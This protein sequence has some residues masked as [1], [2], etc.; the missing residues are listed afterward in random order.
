MMTSSSPCLASPCLAGR[1]VSPLR[2]AAL[3]EAAGLALASAGGA[4]GVGD[5]P[6]VL[7]VDGVAALTDDDCW[8]APYR[9]WIEAGPAEDGVLA[10]AVRRAAH[11]DLFCSMVT[12][13]SADFPLAG[14]MVAAIAVR[15]TVSEEL[16]QDME[17]ALHEAVSNALVHG[18]LGVASMRDLSIAALD[19]YSQ[20]ICDSLANPELARR[21]LEVTATFDSDGVVIDVIDEGA[22]YEAPK[23]DGAGAGACGRGLDLISG[24]ADRC[25]VCDGGRRISMRFRL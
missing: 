4:G 14:R 5:S 3:G 13:S 17:L 21:R 24:I 23:P 1:G 6:A 11:Y 25:E 18:N 16:G 10:A 20:C 8:R 15:R 7:V 19:S 12:A 2:L 22:G 9:G